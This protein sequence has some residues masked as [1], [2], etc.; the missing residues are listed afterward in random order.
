M[1][2][3]LCGKPN[4]VP[5]H[6][7]SDRVYSYD[8]DEDEELLP[9][10]AAWLKLVGAAALWILP[11][12]EAELELVPAAEPMTSMDMAGGLLRYTRVVIWPP[13][14]PAEMDVS[15]V[16]ARARRPRVT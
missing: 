4:T 16:T 2:S 6:S 3:R 15:V 13:G 11:A 10:L 14:V 5:K 1:A 9:R 7:D 8:K 12:S